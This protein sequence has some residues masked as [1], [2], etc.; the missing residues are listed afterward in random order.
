[1]KE[2]YLDCSMPGQSEED[3]VQTLN[4]ISEGEIVNPPFI[5]TLIRTDGFLLKNERK[6]NQQ[7][8]HRESIKGKVLSVDLVMCLW[9]LNSR[10][11]SWRDDPSRVTNVYLAEESTVRSFWEL[12][13]QEYWQTVGKKF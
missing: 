12:L 5:F 9:I 10:T 13:T 8:Q 2:N 3:P 11:P 4:T 6:K 7:Q 1:M